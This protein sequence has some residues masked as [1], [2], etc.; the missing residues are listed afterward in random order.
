MQHSR[1]SYCY[2]YV[3]FLKNTAYTGYIVRL[4]WYMQYM[5]QVALAFSAFCKQK[6]GIAIDCHSIQT[7][8]KSIH[9]GPLFCLPKSVLQVEARSEDRDAFLWNMLKQLGFA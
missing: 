8:G 1:M 9:C 5:M 2:K 4:V 6:N 3:F 7:S